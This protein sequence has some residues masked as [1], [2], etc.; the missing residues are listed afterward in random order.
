MSRSID[1]TCHCGAV[2]IRATLRGADLRPSRCTCSFCRRRQA[3]NVSADFDSL[4]IL[5][6][7]E[8]LSLYQFGTF[9][10]AHYFC[11]HCGIYTHHRRFSDPT[12]IGVN[13]GC[14]TGAQSWTFEPMPWNDGGDRTDPD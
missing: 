5:K 7:A 10:A 11:K 3:G 12:E 1:A 4:T 2:H 13:I 9:Q 8:A 14:I 6:G